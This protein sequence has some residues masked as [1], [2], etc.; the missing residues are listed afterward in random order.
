MRSAPVVNE[1][2]HVRHDGIDVLGFFFCGVCVVHSH[3]ANAPELARDAEIEAN[4]F[5]VADVQITVR[6]RRKARVD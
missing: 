6:L 1:P 4:R 3:V 2:S 5:R